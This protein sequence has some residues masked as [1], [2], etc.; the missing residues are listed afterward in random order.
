MVDLQFCTDLTSVYYDETEDIDIFGRGEVINHLCKFSGSKTNQYNRYCLLNSSNSKI[1]SEC[2]TLGLDDEI[3][4][5]SDNVFNSVRNT[6]VD[7]WNM[8]SVVGGLGVGFTLMSANIDERCYVRTKANVVVVQRGKDIQYATA[9]SVG[10]G[11][12]LLPYTDEFDY[13]LDFILD[14]R[15]DISDDGTI[16][17]AAND[18]TNPIVSTS[19]IFKF[20]PFT[21]TVPELVVDVDDN[22]ILTLSV[23]GNGERIAGWNYVIIDKNPINNLTEYREIYEYTT[24]R[25]FDTNTMPTAEQLLPWSERG[26]FRLK[27]DNKGEYYSIV[28]RSDIDSQYY[29]H[30]GTFGGKKWTSPPSQPY[31]LETASSPTNFTDAGNFL[32]TYVV[33]AQHLTYRYNIGF[34]NLFMDTQPFVVGSSELSI[35][36]P[37]GYI[38]YQLTRDGLDSDI[39]L[40]NCYIRS[41]DQIESELL[42]PVTNK[43][44][45]IPPLPDTNFKIYDNGLFDIDRTETIACING[46]DG[47]DV[48]FSLNSI[49]SMIKRYQDTLGLTAW[50]SDNGMIMV[51][52]GNRYYASTT[53][54]QTKTANQIDV[55]KLFNQ[56]KIGDNEVTSPNGRY[57]LRIKDWDSD[58][59][60]TLFQ[61]PINDPFFIQTCQLTP[62]RMEQCIS[63]IT[64]KYCPVMENSETELWNDARCMC[65]NNNAIVEQLFNV[66]ELQENPSVYQQLIGK[67][68]C[69]LAECTSKITE[70]SF[71]GWYMNGGGIDCSGKI[72][73]CTNIISVNEQGLIDAN[74]EQINNCGGSTRTGG[75]KCSGDCALGLTCSTITGYCETLCTT[76][77]ECEAGKTCDIN[78]NACVFTDLLAPKANGSNTGTIVGIIAGLLVFIGLI[79]VI[80][81]IAYKK[82]KRK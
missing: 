81:V 12:T 66:Q 65:Y 27:L 35:Q 49:L 10:T 7:Q 67:A 33:G 24:A 23:S 1:F 63:T 14:A 52:H 78:D 56:F 61:N 40:K 50:L 62:T 42:P 58:P 80:S 53:S 48:V 75:T 13:S 60:G 2:A 3:V 76:N 21:D 73:V 41:T 22:Y 25:G 71:T 38:L 26:V 55:G 57:W 54:D 34:G 9:L 28:A 68:P 45:D 59:E 6:K 72:T 79:A 46:P 36:A 4:D 16:Y 32:I 11:M 39:P 18:I 69:L 29:L 47:L 8:N 17:Y 70:A 30:L 82:H 77:L 74:V 15:F 37:R 5:D 19:A 31:D 43:T 64:D 44:I 20:N 51:Y